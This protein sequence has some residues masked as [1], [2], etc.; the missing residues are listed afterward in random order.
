[1]VNLTKQITDMKLKHLLVVIAAL[2]F[3]AVACGK[4]EAAVAEPASFS[5]DS[6]LAVASEYVGDTVTVEGD[7]AH[8]C[9][10]GGTKAF[11]TGSDSTVILRCQATAEMGGAFAPDCVGKTLTVRGVVCEVPVA[12]PDSSACENDSTGHNCDTERQAV[13][14]YYVEALSYS[15]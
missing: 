12:M 14:A 1:M 13:K 6:I 15:K 2:A 4:K 11:L 10:H 9:K 5:V 8:L 3:M 7:C